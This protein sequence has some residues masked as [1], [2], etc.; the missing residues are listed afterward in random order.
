MSKDY[1]RSRVIEAEASILLATPS[2]TYGAIRDLYTRVSASQWYQS[3]GVRGGIHEC[4]CNDPSDW[5]SISYKKN[6]QLVLLHA[7]AHNIVEQTEEPIAHGPKFT[8][9]YLGLVKRFLGQDVRDRLA[10][11]FLEHKV[12]TRTWSPEAK[13]GAKKRHATKELAQLLEDLQ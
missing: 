7:F 6:S 12:K 9:A 5:A 2:N 1:M 3:R 10:A 4:R 13:A 8:Q 11:A